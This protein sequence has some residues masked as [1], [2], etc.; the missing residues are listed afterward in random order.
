MQLYVIS[1]E[2]N[3]NSV[4]EGKNIVETLVMYL[5]YGLQCRG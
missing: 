5:D 2:K 4:R 1:L 3:S